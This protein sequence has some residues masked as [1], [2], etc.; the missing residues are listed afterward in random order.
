MA[1]QLRR[2]VTGH[3]AR[4]KAVVSMDTVIASRAGRFDTGTHVQEFWQTDSL[5]PR[6]DGGDAVAER[7]GVTPM[8]RGS[9]VRVLHIPPGAKGDEL[10]RT[11]TIDYFVVMDGEVEMT[12]D[13]GKFV[14]LKKGDTIVMRNTNHGWRNTGNRMCM[15]FEVLIDAKG[16]A[17]MLP[18][19]TG[20]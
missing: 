17:G 18:P 13:D 5:P 1:F 8:P 6:Q 2:V 7:T 14:A 3:D 20:V 16:G 15:L 4:G 9:I 19:N 10:H 11:A 12:L